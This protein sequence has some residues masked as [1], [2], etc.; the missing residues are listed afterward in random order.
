M[1]NIG[2]GGRRQAWASS[3]IVTTNLTS[4]RHQTSIFFV[5]DDDTVERS[6][7]IH[8]VHTAAVSA[9]TSVCSGLSVQ[10]DPAKIILPLSLP[11]N[12]QKEL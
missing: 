7:E 1:A 4:H 5:T 10:I 9:R 2:D 8:P 11:A 3:S 6:G 12:R